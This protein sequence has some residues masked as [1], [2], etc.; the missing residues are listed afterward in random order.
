MEGAQE[1][2]PGHGLTRACMLEGKEREAGDIAAQRGGR[3]NSPWSLHRAENGLCLY[4]LGLGRSWDTL[5][6]KY[7]G[8]L[9]SIFCTNGSKLVLA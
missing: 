8:I 7:L 2:P 4:Q 3:Q 5:G 1:A 6:V 9:M